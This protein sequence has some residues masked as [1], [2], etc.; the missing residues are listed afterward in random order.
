VITKRG[1]R[2]R[3]SLGSTIVFY[4][5]DGPHEVEGLES[6]H[7]A[8]PAEVS[9]LNP[10]HPVKCRTEGDSTGQEFIEFVGFVGL[11]R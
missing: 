3:T 4:T 11:K 2:G 1:F 6:L 9:L 7:G 8:S 5:G 10:L